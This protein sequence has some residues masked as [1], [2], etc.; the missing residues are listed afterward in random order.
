MG[1]LI[2]RSK[3]LTSSLNSNNQSGRT[4]R[5]LMRWKYRIPIL[6][7]EF[8]ISVTKRTYLADSKRPYNCIPTVLPNMYRMEHQDIQDLS[9]I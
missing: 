3:Q 8:Y 2:A 6:H 1:A 9:K 4:A 5:I 7:F